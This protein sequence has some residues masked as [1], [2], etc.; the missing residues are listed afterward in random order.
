MSTRTK[1]ECVDVLKTGPTEWNEWRR[2]H[3]AE[4]IDLR[5]VT[6][7]GL[8]LRGVNLARCNLHGADPSRANLE[9]ADL[10]HADLV[11]ARLYRTNL[12][13]VDLHG[14]DLRGAYLAN[15]QLD[16]ADL[17]HVNFLGANLQ[18]ATLRRA[19]L[20]FAL[21]TGCFMDSAD[22]LDADCGGTCFSGMDLSK[23]RHLER[24]RHSR[25]SE[26]GIQTLAT[27]ARHLPMQFVRGC[28]IEDDVI[29]LFKSRRT[30][31]NPGFYS[32]FISYSHKDREFARRLHDCLQDA[33]VR[34]WRDEKDLQPGDDI[35]DGVT[36]GMEQQER[37]LL[38]ASRHSLSSWWVE[39]ELETAFSMERTLMEE[40]KRRSVLLI[41]LNLDDYMFS[42]EWQSGKRQIVRSRVAAD[43][44]DVAKFDEQLSR[45]LGALKRTSSEI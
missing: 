34:C 39:T 41:P 9:G 36:R 5:N 37:I 15:A 25:A 24:V 38:C 32:A 18:A 13:S 31:A 16:D 2:L 21:F 17:R 3:E 27:S 19:N 12:K 40:T 44:R 29:A 30:N 8:Q 45:L 43:F 4:V 14:A 35:H 7:C 10:R 26:L 6:L 20:Q 22:I 42:Q 33:G 1:T 23:V 28:G 11:R